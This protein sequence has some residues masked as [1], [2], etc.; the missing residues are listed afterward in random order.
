MVAKGTWPNAWRQDVFANRGSAGD[1]GNGSYFF[2]TDTLVLYQSDGVSTWDTVGSLQEAITDIVDIPTAET[3]DTKRLRPDG[4]G[5]VEWVT[6]SG[7]GGDAADVT[8]DATGLDNTDATDVQEA[9]E[10]LDAAITAGG[11]GGG[12]ITQAYVGYNTV[13]GTFDSGWSGGRW[14]TKKITLA[15]ACLLTDI[16]LHVQQTSDTAVGQYHFALWDDNGSG[17]APNSLLSVVSS[18]TDVSLVL[19]DTSTG[20]RIA[21]WV[22]LPVGRWLTAGTYWISWFLENTALSVAYD[23]TGTDDIWMGPA[24]GQMG[25]WGLWST[26]TATDRCYSLRANTIR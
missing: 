26:G 2:A 6:A 17:T 13:G 5:G 21:R 24:G 3:D 25:D 23:D 8:F 15:N 7:S 10:D 11:G 19:E 1:Y 22:S 14:Y 18:D 9:I 20:P 12:G 16:E 4:A